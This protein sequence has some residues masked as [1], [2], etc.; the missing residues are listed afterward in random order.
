MV[1]II[2]IIGRSDSGK[3]TLIERLI[4]E[5]IRRGYRVATVK[6]CVHGF[7]IDREGK[8]TWRHKHAGA[9]AVIATSSDRLALISDMSKEPTLEE[10]RDKFSDGIDIII[11]E[12]YRGENYPK[13]EVHRKDLGKRPLNIKE[14]NLIAFVSDT[15]R[16]PNNRKEVPLLGPDN[17]KGLVDII[18]EKFLKTK[19]KRNPLCYSPDEV[20]LKVNGRDIP[21]KPFVKIMISRV[22]KGMLSTLK[23]C[24]NPSEIEINIK[25][26]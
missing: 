23:N 21:L 13:V 26:G 24:D 6:H 14:D 20:G 19:T 7:E 17:I 1:P 8:D 18:E 9:R 11:T 10:L 3:T 15:Q 5:L 2:S 4:P 25:S 12:G 16:R 22:V